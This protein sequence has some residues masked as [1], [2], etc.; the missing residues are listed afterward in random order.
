MEAVEKIS[1]ILANHL[2]K[3][4]NTSNGDLIAQCLGDD[5]NT[6]ISLTF[7]ETS[8]SIFFCQF[9]RAFLLDFIRITDGLLHPIQEN[10]RTQ[11]F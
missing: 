11:F 4:P 9:C 10:E 2:A 8:D 1:S 6:I 3:L 5:H 7:L